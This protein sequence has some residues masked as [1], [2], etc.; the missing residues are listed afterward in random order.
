MGRGKGLTKKQI[1]VIREL[2][3]LGKSVRFIA[4][5]IKKSPTAVHNQ[6][7]VLKQGRRTKKLGR[8]STFA[9]YFKRAINRT[10]RVHRNER[11]T[12]TSLVAKY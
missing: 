3:H 12:A 8:P 1:A 11:V 9:L 6:I 10:I 4:E 7:A 5:R 2:H